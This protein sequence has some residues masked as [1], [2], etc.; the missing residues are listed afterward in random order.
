[1]K[2]DLVWN[3]VDILVAFMAI[4]NVIALI[5]LSKLIFSSARDDEELS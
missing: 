2:V 1:M 3:V 5:G 4:P